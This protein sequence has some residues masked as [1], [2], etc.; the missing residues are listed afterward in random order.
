VSPS[1]GSEAPA[2][3]TGIAALESTA[4][5]RLSPRKRARISRGVQYAILIAAVVG[6]VVVTDWENV[7]AK[8]FNFSVAGEFVPK[9]PQYLLNTILYT[10]SAFVASIALGL[11]LAL[12]K[13][14]SVKPYRWIATVYIEFFRG[15]PALLYVLTIA[16]AVPLALG[17]KIPS[18]YL[19][20]A[21]ALG[22]V[23]AAYM[24]ESIRAGIQAVPKGQIEAARSLGMTQGQTLA[25]VVIPQ[26]FR[27]VLPPVTN[28]IILLTKDTSL[29]YLMGLST[30]Q[31]DLTKAGR[32]ALTDAEGGLTA[33]FLFGGCYLLLTIPLGF[34][35]RRMERRFGKARA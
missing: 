14:S 27:I 17:V 22:M 24:A 33:L 6:F 3:P 31:F 26:A 13:L 4:P 5:A 19:K 9:I 35:T 7:G 29:I 25:S 28:E 20:V 32:D 8:V 1:P 21:I 15:I 11:I 30:G 23:S 2:G 16:Y 18:I 10:L 12:M 34:L